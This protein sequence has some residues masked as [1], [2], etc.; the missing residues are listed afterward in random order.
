MELSRDVETEVRDWATFG[1]GAG[2]E[3][4]SPEIHAALVARLAD[5][6][7]ETRGEAL[8][9]LAQRKDP[10]VIAAIS[11]EL[12]SDAVNHLAIEAARQMPDESFLPALET[13]LRASP[14][15]PGIMTVIAACRTT[16]S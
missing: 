15:D 4:D 13:L 8:V 16:A 7:D 9:G 6:D 11:K 1:L 2:S 10:R 12:A 3:V 5:E 14:D